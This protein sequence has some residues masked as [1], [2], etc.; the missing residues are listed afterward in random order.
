MADME[1]L[2]R[3]ILAWAKR[4]ALAESRS[5][6]TA[7]DVLCGLC[8]VSRGSRADQLAALWV[9]LGFVESEPVWSEAFTSRVEKASAVA[10]TDQKMPLD[11]TLRLVVQGAFAEDSSLPA[12][13]LLAHLLQQ[14][15]DPA[16]A[17]FLADNERN[18]SGSKLTPLLELYEEARCRAQR[19]QRYLSAEV[20]GQDAAIDMLVGAYSQALRRRADGPQ[21]IFTFLGP[22]GVGKTLL[23]ERFAAA[24]QELE[25]SR[26]AF[27]RFDMGSFAG[28]QNFEQLVGTESYYTK[29]AAGTLTGFVHDN[30]RAVILFDEIEKAH[31]NTLTALL[32]VL[33]KGEL[34]DK[35]LQKAVDFRGCWFIFTTNLGREVFDSPNATGIL[36]AAGTWRA[37]AF[38]IL[39]SARRR[40]NLGDEEK[41]AA[42]PPELVS[43][44]AKGGAVVFSRLSTPDYLQLMRRTIERETAAIRK[45]TSLPTPQIGVD[46]QAALLLL[47][48]HLPNLD[49]RQVVART[50]AWIGQLEREAFE[51]CRKQLLQS[52][53]ETFSIQVQCGEDATRWL[54]EQLRDLRLHIVL[55][56]DDDYLVAHLERL[57]GP[58]SGRVVRTTR[59]DETV[60]V[61]QRYEADLVFLD[62]SIGQDSRSTTVEA[63]L[64]ILKALR[65][66]F[67]DLPVWLYSE[68]PEAR[69]GFDAVIPRILRD[70]GARGFLP[71]HFDR[72]NTV[73][74]EDFLSRIG[75]IV[76]ETAYGQL[77]RQGRRSHLSYHFDVEHHLEGTVVKATLTR[78]QAAVVVG[79]QDRLSAIQFAGIPKERFSAVVGLSRAKRRLQQVVQWL[80]EPGTLAPFGITPPRGF[81][82]AGPPGTGKTLLAKA[83]AGEA[84]L[85]FLAVSAS[86]LQS[87]WVGESEKRVREL[88]R[89]A[90]EYAP[91]VVF[92]DEIDAVG[93][94]RADDGAGGFRNSLLNQ[95]LASMDGFVDG[96]RPVF[97]LAATNHRELLDPALLR[98]GRFDEV[99]P[100]NLPNA[101]A[102][103]DFFRLRLRSVSVQE[104]VD[105]RKLVSLTAG[106]SPAELDR[107][108]REGAY[109]AAAV[110]RATLT[111]D[112]LLAAVRLVRFGAVQE[113][114]VVK[115]EERRLVAYHE[116]GHT[117]AHL[118]LFPEVPVDYLSIVPTEEGALGFLASAHDE[119]TH[120]RTRS[121][122]EAKLAV[123]LA[124]REAE[125]LAAGSPDHGTSGASSDIREAS[126]LAWLA[127]ACWGLDEQIGP[128]AI[129]A[130]PEEARSALSAEATARA[131]HWLSAASTRGRQLLEA[132]RQQFEALAQELLEKE[133]LDEEDIR[134][135]LKQ[136]PTSMVAV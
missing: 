105:V 65:T 40:E 89:L 117:I 81:L 126:R 31:E 116:A 44:L 23:A 98:P 75:S 58:F 57:G 34:V 111:E 36:R 78:V 39:G 131:K 122:V 52:C 14:T 48:S 69:K 77:V 32:A 96:S 43:R 103:E 4:I 59:E 95:L 18:T 55:V 70:G 2:A 102:R 82:L 114:V 109:S 128:V 101:A 63:A 30:P 129:S 113:G 135:F 50:S 67:P 87:K 8:A 41:G 88:F 104:P 99:I 49:A 28:H 1:L 21:G 120:L 124:G 53:P 136:Y 123:L 26:V 134:A 119:N 47:L 19:L 132:N 51:V 76:K 61:V 115:V 85:P 42:L 56:D 79:T 71:C 38:D 133:S 80:R 91:A 45:A 97:V 110:G 127:V 118:C 27:R 90:R 3:E 25:G 66:R 15:S 33:D 112:D 46:E 6:L 16:V 68:N 73:L 60:E 24:L 9:K 100:I 13:R 35:N 108:V 121:D 54:D 7:Q 107:V 20:V 93:Q 22:P 130:F 62:L 64:S 83:V 37:L 94:R 74:A 11:D 17:A 86:E 12:E 125:L 5:M 29:S 10:E 106:L 92:I 72:E 84:N